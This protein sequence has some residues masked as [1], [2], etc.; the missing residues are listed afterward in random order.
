MEDRVGCEFNTTSTTRTGDRLLASRF[1]L[2]FQFQA[3]VPVPLQSAAGHRG[4][5]D[6]RTPGPSQRPPWRSAFNMNAAF[7]VFPSSNQDNQLHLD[8]AAQPDRSHPTWWLD[9]TTIDINIFNCITRI[10]IV[11]S[12]FISD[13]LTYLAFS[14]LDRS[15]DLGLLFWIVIE[16][17]CCLG[18]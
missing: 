18:S 15:I 8:I 6:T 11:S 7:D 4:R 13:F 2:L 17:G 5:Q 16:L 1:L 12:S 10:T 14:V 3:V 9:K